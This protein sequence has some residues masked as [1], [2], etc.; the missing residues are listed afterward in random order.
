MKIYLDNDNFDKY[1]IYLATVFLTILIT[2]R[3][4]SS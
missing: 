3:I 1:N 2:I 4:K